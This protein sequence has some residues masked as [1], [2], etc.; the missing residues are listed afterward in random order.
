MQRP[1]GPARTEGA[2]KR[3]GPTNRI[4]P[5]RW[6]SGNSNKS[7]KP[8]QRGEISRYLID[9]AFGARYAVAVFAFFG[10]V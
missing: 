4:G 5:M 2:K 9:S 6:T 10:A 1:G 8:P 7:G 3:A